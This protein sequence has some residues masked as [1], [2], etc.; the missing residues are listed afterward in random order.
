[1]AP[2]APPAWPQPLTLLASP[3][4]LLKT[5]LQALIQA[6]PSSSCQPYSPHPT[7]VLGLA[8]ELCPSP[9]PMPRAMS[10]LCATLH[11]SVFWEGGEHV[12][13]GKTTARAW[14]QPVTGFSQAP[15]VAGNFHTILECG[16]GMHKMP[17]LPS[18]CRHHLQGVQGWVRAAGSQPRHRSKHSGSSDGV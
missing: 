15:A 18:W 17:K 6:Q 13:P 7:L 1:M 8:Q 5:P 3:V 16:H 10:G 11:T 9:A 4:D 14:R 2:A 12:V